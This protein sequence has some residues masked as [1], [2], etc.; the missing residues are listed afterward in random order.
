[1]KSGAA[2]VGLCARCCHARLVETPRSVFWMCAL[3]ASDARFPRYPRLP[4]LACDGF[5]EGEPQP[6]AA[7]KPRPGE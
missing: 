7:A 1:M 5:A 6:H 4:V 3:A 2:D